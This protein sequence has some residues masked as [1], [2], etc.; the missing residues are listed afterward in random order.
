MLCPGLVRT[1]IGNGERT[2]P[3][4]LKDAPVELSEAMKA[5]KKVF[6]GLLAGS[7]PPEQVAEQVFRAVEEE[8][9]YI[10]THPEWMEL[11]EMR[12]ERLMKLENPVSPAA[13]LA[14]ILKLGA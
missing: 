9:F 14:R 3:E 1:N 7:M 2:R 11:V 13:V 6:D 12:V 4:E 10:V 5:G 8:R